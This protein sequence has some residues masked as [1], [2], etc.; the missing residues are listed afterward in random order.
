MAIKQ[1]QIVKGLLVEV[2][3]AAGYVGLLYG[4]CLIIEVSFR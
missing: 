3:A 1:I 2:V 4:I